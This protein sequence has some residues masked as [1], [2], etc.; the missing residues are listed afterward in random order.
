M[1]DTTQPT[2]AFPTDAVLPEFSNR[3]GLPGWPTGRHGRGGGLLDRDFLNRLIGGR[4]F[5]GVGWAEDK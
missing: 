3:D 5:G 1:L 2:R 4:L